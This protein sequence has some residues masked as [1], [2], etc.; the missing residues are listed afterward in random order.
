MSFR[1]ACI[2]FVLLTFSS[3]VLAQTSKGFLVG[4]VS[5]P[6]GAVISGANVKITNTST[7]VTRDTVSGSDGTFRLDAVEP[8]AYRVEVS[9]TGFKTAVAENIVV[10]ASQTK[11]LSIKLDLGTQVEV[12]NVT[13]VA[14]VSFRH[15]MELVSI[16][17]AGVRSLTCQHQR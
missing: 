7:G 6:N 12:V 11:S 5:D 2:A 4:N 10:D 14:D 8:G 15:R 9:Q 13:S 3:S 1:I 17:S 16:H